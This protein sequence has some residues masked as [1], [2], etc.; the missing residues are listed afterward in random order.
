MVTAQS[1]QSET[2]IAPRC[3]FCE[4]DYTQRGLENHYTLHPEHKYF[5]KASSANN[6][7]AEQSV[8]INLLNVYTSWV[9]K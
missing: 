7:V 3:T 8:E 2:L 4:K 6:Q 9:N 5:K 1:G